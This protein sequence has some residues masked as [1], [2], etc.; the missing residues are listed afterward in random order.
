VGYKGQTISLNIAL[1]TLSI[2]LTINITISGQQVKT[3]AK[4]HQLNIRFNVICSNNL[5]QSNDEVTY[6]TM[7]ECNL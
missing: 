1:N 7:V 4:I 3:L 6:I 5:M 2:V